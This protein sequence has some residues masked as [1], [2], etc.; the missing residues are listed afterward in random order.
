MRIFVA[1]DIDNTVRERIERFMDGVKD[2][3]PE[4]RWAKPESLHVTLK[5]IGERPAEMVE[6][7]KTKLAN[8]KAASFPVIFRGYG[9]FPNA[10]SARV[11]WV[12]IEANDGLPKLAG[13]LDDATAGLG[14]A[15]EDRAFSPHLTL[16]RGGSGTP[17]RQKQEGMNRRLAKLQQKLAPLPPPDFGTMTAREFFLYQ[18]QTSRDGARYSKIARFQLNP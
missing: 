7:I 18:S 16:A 12:G 4:A 8:I 5:F 10:N 11:F 1:L 6:Q 17:G 14:I 2:S 9:F 13:V 15:R 3:A